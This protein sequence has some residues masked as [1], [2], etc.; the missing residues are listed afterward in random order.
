MKKT[1]TVF[2]ISC[3]LLT[4]TLPTWDNTISFVSLCISGNRNHRKFQ[5]NKDKD[6]WFERK[7]AVSMVTWLYPT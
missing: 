7:C 3:K 6:Q 4:K 5:E 2:G 1:V